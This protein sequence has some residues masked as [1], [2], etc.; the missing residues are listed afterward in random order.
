MDAQRTL[1]IEATL[2]RRGVVQAVGDGVAISAGLDEVGYEELVVFDS[3]AFGMATELGPGQTGIVLLSSDARIV[4]GEGVRGLGRLPTIPSGSALLGRIVDPL[5][6]PLD[7]GPP[8]ERAPVREL[9]ARPPEL[10]ERCSVERPLHTG[11]TV[12]DTAIPI[13]RGQRELVV[14]DRDVGKTSLVIDVIVAQ[15]H[16]GVRCVYVAIGQPISR[17]L[18]VRET[19]ARAA[20]LENTVIVAAESSMPPGVQYLAPYAGATVAESLIESGGDALVAYDDLTKHADAYR[21]LALLLG[22]PTGREAFPGDIFHIHAELLERAASL[23]DGRSVTA[24]PIVETTESDISGY[25]PTN[26]ISITDGQIYLDTARF[27]RNERP[28][29]DVGRSVSRIGAAA[30][31]P[32]VRAASR[33]LRLLLARFESL[34]ALT[35]VGLEVEPATRKI[36]ERGALLRELLRQPRLSPRSAR[37]EVFELVAVDKGWL[38]GVPPREAP[39]VLARA[40][41]RGADVISAL[42]PAT[43]PDEGWRQRAAAVVREARAVGTR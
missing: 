10:V 8:I 34:E 27:E 42:D 29:V 21:Q 3:G 37:R 39:T 9:F 40:I 15:R 6:L 12:I 33:N 23:A 20:C 32:A 7:G 17:I 41:E 38:D 13:G 31:P 14:G 36:L 24:L 2:R 22:R 18:A 43:P 19:L 25:I 16:T 11:I 1:D 30:Q 28:A 35:R 26:L 4:A 5:G